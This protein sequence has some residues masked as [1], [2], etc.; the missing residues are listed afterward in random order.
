[1][2]RTRW[3]VTLSLLLRQLLRASNR[4][5]PAR[6]A[7]LIDRLG[8][9][10]MRHRASFVIFINICKMSP[11][12]PPP[13]LQRPVSPLNSPC[14]L[15]FTFPPALFASSPLFSSVLCFLF[16]KPVIF[17]AQINPLHRIRSMHVGGDSCISR[18]DKVGISRCIPFSFFLCRLPSYFQQLRQTLLQNI[19]RVFL[20]QSAFK[21]AQ[22]LPRVL[23]FLF[24]ASP[25]CRDC[26]FFPQH[27]FIHFFAVA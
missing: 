23:R 17:D 22:L 3:R 14:S 26:S 19:H 13:P 4:R 7:S 8:C 20:R 10:A 11:L 24:S 25:S 6:W 1:V 9:T 18:V 27:F 2:Q 21:S 15:L 16:F 5:F 12:S